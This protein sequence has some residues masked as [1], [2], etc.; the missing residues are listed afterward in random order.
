MTYQ[1]SLAGAEVKLR[2]LAEELLHLILADE[3]YPAADGVIDESALD[4][5]GDRHERHIAR[6]PAAG[7]RR[8]GDFD[9][10]CKNKHNYWYSKEFKQNNM[11]LCSLIR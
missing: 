10:M 11:Y 8:L 3:V 2:L 1:V 7:K 9:A 5:L 6:L 4:R